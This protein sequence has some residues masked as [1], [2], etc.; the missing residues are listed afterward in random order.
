M[1]KR[2]RCSRP[3]GAIAF[4]RKPIRAT[5]RPQILA[6]RYRAGRHDADKQFLRT[7][8]TTPASATV[9]TFN[10]RQQTPVERIK[11]ADGQNLAQHV[12]H[13]AQRE[14]SA[15]LPDALM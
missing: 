5:H 14:A 2:W 3:E 8:I 6:A 12:I 10:C 15:S 9:T 13:A 11:V 1:S 4:D 7:V